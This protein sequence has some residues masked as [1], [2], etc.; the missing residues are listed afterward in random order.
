[1]TRESFWAAKRLLK[2]RIDL[3]V[4]V[5]YVG[6]CSH[7]GSHHFNTSRRLILNLAQCSGPVHNDQN[8]ANVM[9]V[10]TILA[11]L[12]LATVARSQTPVSYVGS[13]GETFALFAYE[14]ERTAL[15]VDSADYDPALLRRMLVQ[16]DYFWSAFVEATGRQPSPYKTYNSKPTLAVLKTDKLGG[17]AVGYVGATGV[18]YGYGRFRDWYNYVVSASYDS[19]F[20]YAYEF[21]RNFWFFGSKLDSTELNPGSTDASRV[22]GGFVYVPSIFKW[23]ALKGVSNR[24]YQWSETYYHIN[25][26]AQVATNFVLDPSATYK[27]VFQNDGYFPMSRNQQGSGNIM[28]GLLF[29]L[30]E[31][32][33]DLLTNRFW[34]EVAGLPSAS[35]AAAVIDNYV[36]AA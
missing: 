21:G 35:T 26:I 4:F 34:K 28:Q 36:V 5:W 32:Y 31:E 2:R 25:E 17:A 1:M 10:S 23:W 9:K 30:Q 33:G 24:T 20:L 22:F 29:I 13:T 8:H 7:N 15:L 6:D 3:E 16:M 27:S 18:E 19:D 14:G 12:C 11:L